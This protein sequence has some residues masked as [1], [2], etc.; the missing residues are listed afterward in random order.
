MKK[1]IALGLAFTPTFAFAQLFVGQQNLTGV[2]QFIQSA[3]NIAVVL[4]TAAAVVWFVWGVFTFIMSADDKEARDE[5]R[6]KMIAGIIGIAVIVSVWGLVGWVVGTT[7][8][9]GRG[10]IPP[11]M[12]PQ[13]GG[14]GGM[15]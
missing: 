5:G 13:A 9:A 2:V 4:I 7:G 15:I 10:G 6:T 1:V 12:L 14:L 11:T 3:M 8:T